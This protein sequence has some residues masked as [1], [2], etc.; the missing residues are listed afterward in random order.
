MTKYTYLILNILFFLPNFI[1]IFLFFKKVIMARLKFIL[2]SGLLGLVWFFI[3]DPP[4]TSWGA[5]TMNYSKSVGIRFGN[6]V[7]EELIWA[8]LVCMSVASMIEIYLY[9]KNKK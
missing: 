8:I 3:I 1:I 2:L 7:V 5:W 9:R 6:S 4:A